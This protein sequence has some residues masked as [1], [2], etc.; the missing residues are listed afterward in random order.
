[1]KDN[2]QKSLKSPYY[3][4]EMKEMCVSTANCFAVSS[5]A[6]HEDYVSVDLFD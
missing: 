1:M 5:D 6:D 3:P 2:S 4:P